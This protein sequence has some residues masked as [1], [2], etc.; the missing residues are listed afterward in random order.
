MEYFILYIN[1]ATRQ[2]QIFIS[3]K[4]MHKHKYY[5]NVSECAE[6]KGATQN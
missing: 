4:G 3:N 2:T 6:Y 5:T 1:A